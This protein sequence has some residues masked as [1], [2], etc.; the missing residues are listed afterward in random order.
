VGPPELVVGPARHHLRARQLRPDGEVRDGERPAHGLPAEQEPAV[1]GHRH[2]RV[3]ERVDRRGLVEEREPGQRA[4]PEELLVRAGVGSGRGLD[5]SCVPDA[6]VVDPARVRWQE[7]RAHV[8]GDAVVERD[9]ADGDGAGGDERRA[10]GD[11]GEPGAE[12]SA[13]GEAGERGR[14]QGDEER[15]VADADGLLQPEDAHQERRVL[16]RVADGVAGERH[17]GGK[18]DQPDRDQRDG[19]LRRPSASQPEPEGG[20]GERQE[21]HQVALLEA[22]GAVG[23]IEGSLGEEAEQETDGQRSEPALL[24]GARTSERVGDPDDRRGHE[25]EGRRIREQHRVR[26]EPVDDVAR[27]HVQVGDARVVPEQTPRPER[28]GE[29][30]RGCVQQQREAEPPPRRPHRAALDDEGGRDEHRGQE[31]VLNARE[32]REHRQR[33]E[34]ELQRRVGSASTQ[35]PT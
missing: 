26:A 34:G 10:H 16:L 20:K 11:P 32:G 5:Q 33:R 28:R 30:E 1:V 15:P 18:R 19:V 12:G 25:R 6:G 31:H 22:A 29:R 17:T 8:R 3:A 23:R 35:T 2:A 27:L 24:A 9:R 7:G 13:R 14:G 21:H 4:V